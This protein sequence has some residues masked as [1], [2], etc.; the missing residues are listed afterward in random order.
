ME[1]Q[2]QALEAVT[3][4]RALVFGT[5]NH[6]GIIEK[7]TDIA[8]AARGALGIASPSRVF[9]D[10]IGAM[11]PAGLTLGIDSGARDVQRSMENLTAPQG[12]PGFGGAQ[13]APLGFGGGS[14]RL[15]G[16]AAGQ[17][18]KTA[19]VNQHTGFGPSAALEGVLIAALGNDH[20]LH[21]QLVLARKQEVALVVGR[22]AH[23]GAGAVLRQHVEIGRAHV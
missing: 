9:R 3:P 5:L 19:G 11:I 16:L 1:E 17:A 22:H 13:G 12:L 23:H 6:T 14:D 15:L 21:R 4:N 20:L 2:S 7:A 8:N 10:E 18:V